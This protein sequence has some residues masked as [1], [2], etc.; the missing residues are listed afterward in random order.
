MRSAIK[1]VG[2]KYELT[3]P[4]ELKKEGQ[5]FKLRGIFFENALIS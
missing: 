3:S 2:K 1:T 5:I 4:G